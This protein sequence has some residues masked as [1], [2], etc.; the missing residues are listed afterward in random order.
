MNTRR[1]AR[2]RRLLYALADFAARFNERGYRVVTRESRVVQDGY[3]L[4]TVEWYDM[5]RRDILN[6]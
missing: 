6:K 3:M 4:R 2:R 5:R 1:K